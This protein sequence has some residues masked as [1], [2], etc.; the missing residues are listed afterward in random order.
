MNLKNFKEYL[1]K[2]TATIKASL[3]KLENWFDYGFKEKYLK[4]KK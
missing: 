1:T 2:D 4:E 3:I